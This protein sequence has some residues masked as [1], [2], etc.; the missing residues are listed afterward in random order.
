VSALARLCP[1]PSVLNRSQLPPVLT[2]HPRLSI[3]PTF[4]RRRSPPRLLTVARRPPRC[5]PPSAPSTSVSHLG[6]PRSVAVSL[7]LS[8]RSRHETDAKSKGCDPVELHAAAGK[9]NRRHHRSSTRRRESLCVGM[10]VLKIENSWASR[11]FVTACD[12]VPRTS[13]LLDRDLML[14]IFLG[15]FSI[16][17]TRV[18]VCQKG[19]SRVACGK[20]SGCHVTVMLVLVPASYP[21]PRSKSGLPNTA[22][23]S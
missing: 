6:L 12:E 22:N 11:D 23:N 8:H 18:A 3:T 16:T 13:P 15:R 21:Q 7:R 10:L 2:A 19:H 5:P 20:I 14:P 9:R 4:R 17:E 1:P